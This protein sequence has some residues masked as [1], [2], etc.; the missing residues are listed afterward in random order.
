[1]KYEFSKTDLYIP[2]WNGNQKLDEAD[3]VKVKL[4]CMEMG[5]VLDVMDTMQSGGHSGEIDSAEL[6]KDVTTISS[7]IKQ[8][9]VLLPKYAVIENLEGPDGPILVEDICRYPQFIALIVEIIFRLISISTP[10]EDDKGN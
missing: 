9:S 8:S 7:L 3:Q 4:W 6:E 5:D 10:D 1:M 2:E